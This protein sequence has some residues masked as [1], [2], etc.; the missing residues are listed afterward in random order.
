MEYAI[1]I[2]DIS[3]LKHFHIR[4]FTRVYYGSE[5]CEHLM[6]SSAQ[7]AAVLDFA[8]NYKAAFT[9]VTPILYESGLKKANELLER[10]PSG[11]EVVIN[12]LGLLDTAAALGLVPVHGRLL[13]SSV[14]DPRIGKDAP[15]KEY[16]SS[17]NIQ[18]SYVRMMKARGVS[19][20][21][22]DNVWQ[23][24]DL[25]R[26]E[27]V[28]MSLYYP[29]VSCST[30]RKCLFANLA[31]GGDC[32][33]GGLG[34]PVSC[35]RKCGGRAIRADLAG[36][37][38]TIMGNAQFYRNDAPPSYFDSEPIDRLVYMPVIPNS[39]DGVETTE[40]LTWSYPYKTGLY[41]GAWGEEPDEVLA[42]LVKDLEPAKGAKVL[43]AGCGAGRNAPPLIRLGLDYLGIDIAG[44]ALELAR[45]ELPCVNFALVD[46]LDFEGS[47]FDL[48]VDFGCFHTLAP[49]KRNGYFNSMKKA[50]RAG[51]TLIVA[52][53]SGETTA[54]PIEYSIGTL[55]EWACSESDMEK[56]ASPE[57]ETIRVETRK[58]GKWTMRYYVMAKEKQI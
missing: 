49:W 54:L 23:S 7:M 26:I 33:V 6:P 1:F 25:S 57:F 9:L 12:D 24:Y 34:F 45:K 27:G 51:G 40:S 58:E 18:S 19:R 41:K 17:H 20:I 15:F 50:V 35:D 53:W 46:I 28:S 21:E 42:G 36:R 47:G 14:K 43:D 48:A 10:L 32:G 37:Q 11:T 4:E 8:S 22:I 52:A 55:P 16:F 3:S 39:N 13:L 44:S 31:G 5:F 2:S 56:L 30:T 38:I 29:F